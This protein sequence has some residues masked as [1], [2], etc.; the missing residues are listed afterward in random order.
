MVFKKLII[1]QDFKKLE[2]GKIKEFVKDNLC[3]IDGRS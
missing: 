1:S 2:S 3:L